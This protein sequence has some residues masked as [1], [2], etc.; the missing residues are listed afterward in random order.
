MAAGFLHDIGH[1]P[2]SHALDYVLKKNMGKSHEEI[3]FDVIDKLPDVEVDG[4]IKSKVKDIIK[5]KH[6]YPFVSQIVNGPLDA[7][8][9]DYLLRDAHH[10]GLK[11][12][13]DLEYF[14]NHFKILGMDTSNLEKCELGLSTDNTA[15]VT[16]EIFVI[17]W[18][19][20]YDLVYHVENSRIAEKML[21]KAILL[22]IMD[23]RGFKDRFVSIKKFL[24]L[25]DERL[26]DILR[27]G[28]GISSM[29]TERIIDNNL[30]TKIYEKEINTSNFSLNDKFLAELSTNADE[31]AH[32]IDK[33]LTSS[34]KCKDEELICDIIKSRSPKTINIDC[35]EKETG[36]P[37]ELKSVSDIVKAISEKSFVKVY[38]ASQEVR[39][40]IEETLISKNLSN[41]ICNWS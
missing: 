41:I 23:D 40:K 36:D 8:K 20:M 6:T 28:S 10:V 35:Y 9:L 39:L 29:L 18:K 21:E 22:R 25:N 13:L 27:K 24:D 16:A 38:S 15:I 32:K 26:L 1:G 14:I 2:F 33:R 31:L 19:S 34:I 5:G 3:A 17:I 12:S 4:I 7:D 37:I 30:Y 11:Y